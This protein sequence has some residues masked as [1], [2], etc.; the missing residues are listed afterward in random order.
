MT[1]PKC[2]SCGAPLE[3]TFVD[4]GMSPLANS[5]LTAE[6]ASAMEP[7]YPLH[8]R[9]CAKC[10]LVQL[11][12]FES[13]ENIFSNYLYFSSYSDAWLAHCSRY[14]GKMIEMLRLGSQSKVVEIASNDGY[15][16]QF[17]AKHKIPVLGIEPARNVARVA[18][19]KGIPS[20]VAFFG[21]QT[22][23]RL[24]SEHAAD[25][26]A[27]NNVLAHVPDINDFVSGFK[28]LLK[29]GGT[30]T[31]EFPHLLHLIAENQFDTI[32]HEHYSYLS[33]LSV[34]AI[35]KRHGLSLH[36]VEELPTHGGSL[37]IFAGHSEEGRPER[38]GLA[39]VRE[40]ERM[41]G[42]DRVETYTRFAESVVA[43]KSDVLA[44]LIE[45]QRAGK[46][47][48]GYGAAAKGNTLLNY[49]GIGP[50]F[51]S[52]VVDRSPHK[53][54]RLLPGSHIPVLA[55][56]AVFETRPDYLF[57]LPWNLRDEIAGQ[58]SGIREWGGRFVTPIPRLEIF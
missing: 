22:A 38:P 58:M 14:A 39:A 50:E 29:P 7:F 44:F 8:A 33:L 57:I 25:L 15:L 1:G 49:C 52:Y 56:S 20:E 27:A 51:I 45:Q 42:L 48:V 17:F 46:T 11:E 54:G 40:K 41:A 31:V 9:V 53:Q 6:Q 30:I 18:I 43:R 47:V 16:L 28:I 37:R 5:L 4:L 19:E 21:S 36:D 34:E 26:I 55:P 23:S 12:E 3:A 24:K 13:P 35:F 10:F 2:R 32:Y